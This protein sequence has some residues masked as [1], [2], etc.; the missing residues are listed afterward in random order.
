MVNRTSCCLALSLLLGVLYGRGGGLWAAAGMALF[1]AFLLQAVWRRCKKRAWLAALLRGAACLALF[2]AAYIRAAEAQAIFERPGESFTKGDRVSVQGQISKIEEKE[3]QFIYYLKDAQVLLGS[4]AYPVS[5][6]LVYSSNVYQPGNILKVAGTYEPFQISRNQGNFNEKEYYR[7]KN[8][9]FRVYAQQEWKAVGK[10]SRYGSFLQDLRK[11]LRE[12]LKRSL[13][14][15]QAGVMANMAL[16]DKSLLDRELK[17][18]YQSAGI[19]HI[20]A[21]SGLHVS[22]IGMG[23]FRL[24]CRLRCPQGLSALL[25]AGMVYSFASLSGMELSTVRAL[26]MFLLS[27]AAIATGYTYDSLT[28]LSLSAA[29]Q[30]WDNP[31]VLDYA[32][33]LFSYGAVMGITVVAKVLRP[34]APLAEE[35]KAAGKKM[36]AVSLFGKILRKAAGSM[37]ETFLASA[38]IQLATLPLSLY[39]YYECSCYS[40]AVNACILPFMGILLFLG[41]CGAAAG[42]LAGILGKAILMP[43]SLLLSFQEWI[44]QKS[45]SL[46]GAALLTGKP[47][48]LL[49]LLYYLV[50]IAA[51]CMF[52]YRRKQKWKLGI[53]LALCALLF[54]RREKQFAVHILDVGQGDGIFIQT[55]AG[56]H[57]FIDGGSSDVKQVGRYRILPFLKSKGIPSIKGWIVSHA[58]QDHISGLEEL[59]EAGYPIESLILAR[60]IVPDEACQ[61]LLELAEKSGCQILYAAPGV[62]FG[63]GDAV[64]TALHP[65]G[66]EPSTESVSACHADRNA[67][68]LVVS[69]RHHSFTGLFSGDIAAGQEEQILRDGY[70]ERYK[71]HKIDLY[72]AAHHGSNGSNSQPFLDTL[73][74][75]LTAISCGQGNSYGHPGREAMERLSQAGSYVIC[76][77]ETGQI[78]IIPEGAALRISAYL[79]EK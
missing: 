39:F 31:F 26:L 50:L 9:S 7:S 78:T 59:L 14:P 72:K 76:T 33:F 2:L 15:K 67:A 34:Q 66:P 62:Q 63:T 61:N 36:E 79:P 51:L 32:G 30:I 58:D 35:D 54:V 43:A 40:V 55:E 44:C 21:I 10:E 25:S 49:I 5:G 46:P 42:C 69:L 12:S 75:R 8:I 11:K 16:G 4:K 22:L 28:A 56:G 57:F 18:L 6:I 24:L 60:G 70:L 37:R 27:M 41:I 53:I 3:E 45:L 13:P 23:V 65:P 17:E 29:V 19:S 74:P 38:C 68:S 52:H 47:P 71:L 48:F 73:S 64:F 1:L 77:A 20:L